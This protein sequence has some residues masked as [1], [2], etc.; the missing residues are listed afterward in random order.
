MSKL[1]RRVNHLS[2][3]GYSRFFILT[4]IIKRVY[5]DGSTTLSIL[6][7]GGGSE[8][9]KQQLDKMN[10]PYDLTVIDILPKPLH[11]KGRYVQGDATQMP[12]DTAQFDVV[13]STDVLEHV[14]D[15]GKDKFVK[16]CVR[17]SKDLFILAAPFET[18]GVT[19]AETEVNN[20][21]IKLFGSPQN[22]LD[23]HL[24]L[25]KPK[26]ANVKNILE[27]E[28]VHY[29]NF[30]TQNLTTWILNTHLNLIDAKLGLS[31][32]KHLALNL[33][34]NDNFYS[35]N[36]FVGP[37]YRHFFVA[38]K[39]LSSQKRI[40]DDLYSKYV[41]D[42]TLYAQYISQMFTLLSDRISE[43]RTLETKIVKTERELMT[44][45]G[46]LN[47]LNEVIRSQAARLEEAA[48]LLKVADSR[49][50]QAIRTIKHAVR[51]KGKE[52]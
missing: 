16:E 6:D 45:H 19:E 43:I 41:P 49:P 33:F 10:I 51:T 17:V 27:S 22:W 38:T 34:Y 7:V 14:P 52:S 9:M 31:A 25:G 42:H 37:T 1:S 39:Q 46:Q 44:A 8:Y 32:K 50:V 26:L 40:K 5:G 12:F 3:D 2:P 29:V 23:E 47:N 35:M 21:N 11:M 28:G 36:E 20:F 18:E 48:P 4:D 24:R 15:A 13:V 30:G